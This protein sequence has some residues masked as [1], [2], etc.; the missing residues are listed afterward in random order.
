MSAIESLES[1]QEREMYNFTDLAVN[2]GVVTYRY[3]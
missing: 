3:N 2:L 1:V